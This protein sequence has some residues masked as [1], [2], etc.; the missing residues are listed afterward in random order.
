MA[1]LF[2]WVFRIYFITPTLTLPH[3]RLRRIFD[4]G[5]GFMSV[6]GGKELFDKISS[7]NSQITNKIQIRTLND[8]NLFGI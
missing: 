8:S 7:S 3:P 2:L 4:N 6:F 5:E 1:S